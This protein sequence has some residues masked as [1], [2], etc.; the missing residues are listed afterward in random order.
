MD[1]I[2]II[3]IAIGL[4]MDS[5]AVSIASGVSIKCFKIK[6]ILKIAFFLAIFQGIMPLVGWF[7]GVGFKQY[8]TEIDH[9][10]AFGLLSYLGIK[11]IIDGFKSNQEKD[12]NPLK[13]PVLIGL[14]IATSIDA[15]AVGISFAFLNISILIPVL[16][17]GITTFLFSFLG[18]LVGI[19]FGQ[20]YNFRIEIIGGIILVGIGVKI[21]L[22]H[23]IFS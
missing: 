14:S 10:I 12:C 8:I 23:T 22:E 13:F 11:M 16:I 3:L 6:D 5:L 9:W 7:A 1:I 17:I 19:R 2:T 4:S 21:L 15:L 20:K 18:V